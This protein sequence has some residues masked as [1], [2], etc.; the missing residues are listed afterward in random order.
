M[1]TQ[2][3]RKQVAL[4][5]Q[6]VNNKKAEDVTLLQ[7]PR[8]SSAFT[9]Y[10]LI[11]SGSNPRQVQAI[12]DEVDERLSKDMG[13]E[14]NA[15][16]GYDMAEWILL[17]YVDFVIHIFNAQRRAYYDLERLWKSAHKLTV[18]ELLNPKAAAAEAEAPKLVKPTRKAPVKKAPAKSVK[19]AAKSARGTRAKSTEKAPA[20][21]K[22]AAKKT[23]VKKTAVKKAS[24]KKSAAKKLK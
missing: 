10:F 4:A 14:P 7:L 3:I 22:T 19:A 15:R 21:K 17:D 18:E 8:E 9:D 2:D 5:L 16:E 6:A 11:C 13:V 1:P 20:R 12:A 23:A 24:A